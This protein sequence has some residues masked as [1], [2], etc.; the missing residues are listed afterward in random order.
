M[1]DRVLLGGESVKKMLWCH[2]SNEMSL[3]AIKMEFRFQIRLW[4]VKGLIIRKFKGRRRLSPTSLLRFVSAL[5]GRGFTGGMG[6][7]EGCGTSGSMAFCK[8]LGGVYSNLDPL[9]PGSR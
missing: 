3:A 8:S 2:N 6:F 5:A 7:G 4:R 1:D 9:F